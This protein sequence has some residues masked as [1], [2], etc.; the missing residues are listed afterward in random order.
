I[1]LGACRVDHAYLRSLKGQHQEAE[2]MIRA[3]MP[4]RTSGQDDPDLGNPY[5]VWAAVRA[6]AGDVNGAVEKLAQAKRGGATAEDGAKYAERAPLTSRA[7]YPP[8]GT[9]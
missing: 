5:V 7:G 8:A 3:A 4:L 9:P 6:R 2:R 1:Y